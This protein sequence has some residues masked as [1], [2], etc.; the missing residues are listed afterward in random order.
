MVSKI[1]LEFFTSTGTLQFGQ[2]CFPMATNSTLK[3][4][5]ISVNVP[6]VLLN[7]PCVVR[8]ST[9]TVGGMFIIRSKLGFD[10][11]CINCLA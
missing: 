6:T 10:A 8:C 11:G 1:S 4:W 2:Y 9:A 5:E 3:K 7:P